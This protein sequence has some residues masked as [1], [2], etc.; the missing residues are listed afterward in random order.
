MAKVIALANQKGGVGKTTTAINLAASMAVLEKKI[1]LIDADPQ[2]NATSGFGFD[3][4]SIKSSI[5]ECVIENMDP[6]DIMLET[7]IEGLKLIPSN[8]DLV[9][10]EI[11]ILQLPNREYL[12]KGVISKFQHEFDYIL[13]DCSP[14]LGLITLNALTAADSVIIPVQCEYFALEGL[15]KL[16]NTIK[17]VQSKLNESL[18]IEGFLLTMY[19]SRLRLGNQVVEEVKSHFDN[20]VFETI[21]QRN[22]KLSEAPSYG[23]PI[24]LYDA[25]SNGSLN[26][27]NLAK[28][29]IQ[30]N[31]APKA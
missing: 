16:L 17:I 18:E 27:L 4:R 31:E 15:G 19:D 29:L 5:Y 1:L 28:E 9:G 30:K 8:I 14:S 22:V 25:N 13:I 2:A 6:R 24:I 7:E 26:Y 11:E 21:I 10:A 20:M 12:L 3:V 23:K